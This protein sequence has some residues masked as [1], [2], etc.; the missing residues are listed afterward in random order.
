VGELVGYAY[1]VAE[2]FLKLLNKSSGP[3][4]KLLAVSPT[5][6]MGCNEEKKSV[7]KSI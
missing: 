5:V 4:S 7:R 1:R 6:L 3:W 2:T